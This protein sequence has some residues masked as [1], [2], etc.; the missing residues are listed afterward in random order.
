MDNLTDLIHIHEKVISSDIC[1]D[2]INFFESNKSKHEY[3]NS[4]GC[5][6]FTQLNLTKNRNQKPELHNFLI[7]KVLEYRNNYY[8]SFSENLFPNAH[9]FEEFRIKR[10]LPNRKEKF[11][12]HVDVVDYPSSRRFLSFFWY[13]ND[14]EV[15]G[16]TVFTNLVIKPSKGNLV[17]FPPLWMFPH[18]GNE[19]VSG[20]KYL[21]STYLHYK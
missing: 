13:L 1:N 18:R 9:A 12:T 5:P 21:L 15:G 10:Y 7:K 19:P 3:I 16:E 4:H 11:D 20:P 2:L 8:S 17:I 14:V 6:T